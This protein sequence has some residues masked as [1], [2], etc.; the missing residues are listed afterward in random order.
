MV[1]NPRLALLN[2]QGLI[3][4]HQCLQ[5]GEGERIQ[6]EAAH[7]EEVPIDSGHLRVHDRVAPL[8]D[9]D[10]RCYQPTIEAPRGGPCERDVTL[11]GEQQTD[12][13]ASTGG[14]GD[15]AHDARIWQKVTVCNLDTLPS[16]GECFEVPSTHAPASSDSTEVNAQRADNRRVRLSANH[17]P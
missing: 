6:I 16:L 9:N 10:A 17:V 13:N 8:M 3:D 14:S 5:V 7:E 15:R 11:T 12:I 4:L 1:L 2:D